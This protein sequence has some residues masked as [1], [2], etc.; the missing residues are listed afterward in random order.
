[1]HV[2]CSQSAGFD[3]EYSRRQLGTDDVEKVNGIVISIRILNTTLTILGTLL[4]I[5]NI[6]FN[7]ANVGFSSVCSSSGFAIGV[8]L[9]SV[10]P[11][12]LTSEDF[13]NKHLRFTPSMGGI[14]TLESK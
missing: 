8:M 14:M 4:I 9:G 13:C 3:A 2:H 12:L 10:I 5:V 7:R 6:V 1:V 11:V